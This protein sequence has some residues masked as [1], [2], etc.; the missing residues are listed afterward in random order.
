[1]SKKEH[2]EQIYSSNQAK[3]LGWYVPHVHPSL[4]WIKELNLDLDSPIIDVGGVMGSKYKDL[5][6][7][8]IILVN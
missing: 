5:L 6:L 1:M 4:G 2:W 8:L 3:T 7:L